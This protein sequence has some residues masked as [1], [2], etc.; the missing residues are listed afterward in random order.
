MR[1]RIGCLPYPSD[2]GISD[3]DSIFR[4]TEPSF[5]VIRKSGGFPLPKKGPPGAAVSSVPGM[6]FYPKRGRAD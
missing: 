3:P 6:A 2:S 4:I 1:N 5:N